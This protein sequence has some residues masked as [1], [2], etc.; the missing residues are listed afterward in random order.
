MR[1]AIEMDEY[2]TLQ[3]MLH[4]CYLML[5]D[6]SSKP[7]LRKFPAGRSTI[8][9]LIQLSHKFPAGGGLTQIRPAD[10]LNSAKAGLSKFMFKNLGFLH[11]VKHIKPE[12]LQF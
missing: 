3:S 7:A 11:F 5:H 9:A 10:G 8:S 6:W 12:K 4:V 2:N 1:S